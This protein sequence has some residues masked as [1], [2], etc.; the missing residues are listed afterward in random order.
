[1]Q[2]LGLKPVDSSN[3]AEGISQPPPG[4]GE[5][6]HLHDIENAISNLAASIFWI[7]KSFISNLISSET[8]ILIGGN[9]HP[10]GL[11]ME[12]LEANDDIGPNHTPILSTGST[13]VQQL[14]ADARLDVREFP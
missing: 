1:M 10:S 14:V 11:A 13:T 6:L 3:P 8:D 4:S 7:G 5:L 12:D 2:Q 9:V